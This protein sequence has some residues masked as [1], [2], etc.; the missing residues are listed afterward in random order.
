VSEEFLPCSRVSAVLAIPLLVSVRPALR[1]SS[2]EQTTG[3]VP[4]QYDRSVK[5]KLA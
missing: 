3:P 1:N 2:F 4:G 5:V